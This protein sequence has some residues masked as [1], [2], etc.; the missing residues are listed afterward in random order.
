MR[1]FRVEDLTPAVGAA[2]AAHGV[3]Q[4]HRTAGGTERARRRV[5]RPVRSPATAGLRTGGLALRDGHEWMLL[6][7][8][9]GSVVQLE[10]AQRVPSRVG[11]VGVAVAVARV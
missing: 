3:G 9:T 7:N 1:L 4:L 11:R 6:V 5:Q 10:I 8:R 2:V